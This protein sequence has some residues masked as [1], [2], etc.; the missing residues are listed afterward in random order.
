MD[1]TKNHWA[2]VTEKAFGA[3]Q[4][5]ELGTFY[6]NL[7]EPDITQ[8]C[9]LD[10]IVETLDRDRCSGFL[11]DRQVRLPWI[12]YAF[13][14]ERDM[15]MPLTVIATACCGDHRYVTNA[16]ERRSDLY[17]ACQNGIRFDRKD[18][19]RKRSKSKRVE[20]NIGSNV[21]C[22]PAW[23]HERWQLPEFRFAK[24]RPSVQRASRAQSGP[25]YRR[26]R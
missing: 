26:N 1:L 19:R 2:R 17:L 7:H 21:N 24:T 4:D 15:Q 12:S 20:A 9:P 18:L 13:C 16:R 5:L 22:R 8:A 3:P 11:V 23:V 10:Q 6:V 25:G 14:G